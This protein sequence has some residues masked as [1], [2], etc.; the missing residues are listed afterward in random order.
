VVIEG[1]SV[2]RSGAVLAMLLLLTACGGAP[3][4][5]DLPAA[6][7]QALRQGQNELATLIT[8]I[9]KANYGQQ[10]I[11]P[12]AI[13]ECQKGIVLAKQLK[14]RFGSYQDEGQETT[15]DHWFDRKIAVLEGYIERTK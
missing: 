9:T 7:Q 14:E 1:M 15:L 10:A 4:V 5:K 6:E 8:G 13:P 3:S 12:G 2:T 11:N